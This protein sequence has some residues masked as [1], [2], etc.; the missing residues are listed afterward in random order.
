MRKLN[1]KHTIK[2]VID[3][4]IIKEEIKAR[5]AEAVEKALNKSFGEVEIEILNAKELGM[6]KDFIHYSEHK[7]CFKC[8]VSFEELEP[9]SFSFN[10]P[11]GACP[12]CDGLGLV[13]SL[14]IEKVIK[15]RPLNKG[16]IPLI[17]GFN[18]KYYQE[19]F[20]AFCKEVG[21]D[22]NKSFY[23][24]DELQ[25]KLIL[26]GTAYDITFIYAK[27]TISKPWPG[28]RQIAL[29]TYKDDISEI[30][31]ESTCPV[32]LGYRLKPESLAVKV[33]G[34]TIAEIISMPIEEAY[35]FFSNKKILNIYPTKI[36]NIRTYFKRDKRKTLFF[37]GCGA[38]IFNTEQGCKNNKRWRKPENQNRQPDR[39]RTDR[40]AVCIG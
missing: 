19:F 36:K 28:L 16:A 30:M 21:I 15:D 7:A 25:K 32:C 35:K 23:E 3:R 22:M 9:T 39:K 17:W 38:W 1:L 5:I 11:K 20:K 34:K 24:L 29:D 12:K 4:V 27:H 40:G 2:A 31:S 8:K 14:D 37:S 10:S 26:N 18:K 13:Y 6:E 33:A